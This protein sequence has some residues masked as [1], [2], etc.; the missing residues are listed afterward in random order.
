MKIILASGSPRRLELLNTFNI[1]FDVIPSQID[2][3]INPHET[4][5]QIV[6][7]LALEKALDVSLNH[8]DSIIIASDT[9]VYCDEVLGKPAS[10]DDARR[11]LEKLS[12]NE[13]YVYTG[14]ALVH[15]ESNKKIVE[16]EKTK[17]IFNTLTPKEIE[18]Y[19]STGEPLD[20]AGAYGAQ[21]IGAVLVNRMEG[22]FYNVIGLPLSR[23]NQ[24]MKQYF[25]IHLL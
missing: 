12:G 5:E 4:P 19:I 7:G 18:N 8:Q 23:L 25:D 15:L 6:M 24:M 17:V 13:H 1:Q 11:M 9:I 14:I 2:E 16:F 21:G 3:I 22:D 20:K 10:V